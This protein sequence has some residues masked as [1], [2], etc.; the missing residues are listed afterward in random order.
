MGLY[1]Y[2]SLCGVTAVNNFSGEKFEDE[3]LFPKSAFQKFC[4]KKG[5]ASPFGDVESQKSI[6]YKAETKTFSLAEAAYLLADRDFE[7]HIFTDAETGEE[8]VS[9]PEGGLERQIFK[10]LCSSI[11]KDESSQTIYLAIN[12]SVA[13]PPVDNPFNYLSADTVAFER[14]YYRSW[15]LGYRGEKGVLPKWFQDETEQEEL[16]VEEEFSGD[17]VEGI[18]VDF[19]KSMLDKNSPQYVPR[20][21]AV[22]LLAQKLPDA[23]KSA[24]NPWN[25]KSIHRAEE[26]TAK[27]LLKELGIL[28]NGEVINEDVK[29]L[30]RILNPE[31]A[32]AE[33]RT[34]LR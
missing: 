17:I 25:A 28:K 33:G 14:S 34:P 13:L 16:K 3:F 1:H 6:V 5:W 7:E 32:I 15:W 30:L 20:L 18:N 10:C 26:S 21:L 2:A 4:E 31:K 23:R 9:P 27:A 11:R 12:D 19:V 29:A 22:V 24:L 8:Y